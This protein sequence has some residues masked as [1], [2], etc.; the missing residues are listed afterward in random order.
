ML[1]TI[2]EPLR[3]EW[4]AVKAA[5]L[6]FAEQGKGAEA[7]TEVEAFDRRLASFRFLD[8]ACGW[9][10]FVRHP[11][12][13]EAAGGRGVGGE[14]KPGPRADAAG[15]GGRDGAARAIR[16]HRG[17][18]LGCGN[19]R[20]ALWIGFL[21][22]HRRTRGYYGR[23]SRPR[24]LHNIECRD[25]VLAW[26]AVEPL[27]D[28][29][30]Q[31]VT[32]WDGPPPSHTR[33]PAWRG[34]TKHACAGL[35]LRQPVGGGMAGGGFFLGTRRSLGTNGC[36]PPSAMVTLRLCGM[37]TKMCQPRAT[38]NVLVELR[39]AAARAQRVQQFGF[40]TTNS[41]TQTFNRR[42]LQFHLSHE[43]PLSIVFAIPDH[44]WVDTA[45]GANVRISMTVAKPGEYS[46]D[47]FDRRRR[48]THGFSKK[49]RLN[50]HKTPLEDR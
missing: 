9:G 18:P 27:L 11:R 1:P 5:A 10:I 48:N 47:P 21:Q 7:L 38:T 33:S 32:N 44:P 25:A 20:A 15:D 12:T 14:P 17:D 31:L 50:S 28:A 36:V 42:V 30:G 35:A 6:L 49:L 8:L 26:D 29:A 40:V 45:E 34:P 39:C 43:Q 22:W 19:R 37:L 3:N 46:R 2:V 16:R 13:F 24:N 4:D 41:I 23:P